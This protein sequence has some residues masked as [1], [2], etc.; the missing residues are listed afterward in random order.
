MMSSAEALNWQN[1]VFLS[2]QY[3]KNCKLSLET[4]KVRQVSTILLWWPH[5]SDETEF[6]TCI[7]ESYA[8]LDQY[9]NVYDKMS[10]QTV[11]EN[12]SS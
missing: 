8:Q 9:C 6:L 5:I 2:S 12:I 10:V 1:N 7:Y 11:W 3:N 4:I